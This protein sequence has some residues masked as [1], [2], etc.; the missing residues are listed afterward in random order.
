MAG[1]WGSTPSFLVGIYENAARSPVGR[2]SRSKFRM[3]A[4][5][6]ACKPLILLDFHKSFND[7]PTIVKDRRFL[8]TVFYFACI[9]TGLQ[10]KYF[11]KQK[12]RTLLLVAVKPR[13][14]PRRRTS[15][16]PNRRS[17]SKHPAEV[18]GEGRSQHRI[19]I[20][21]DNVSDRERGGGPLPFF[22]SWAVSI[23]QEQ[24]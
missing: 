14:V 7:T 21:K 8:S 4:L 18:G 22:M 15:G 16:N 20:T 19:P 6:A 5:L 12:I 10:L 24:R 3:K 11:Y 1:L 23:Y 17:Q 2:R 13:P 9:H